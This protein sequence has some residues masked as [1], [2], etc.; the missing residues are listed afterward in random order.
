VSPSE[1]FTPIE[2]LLAADDALKIYQV[3]RRHLYQLKHSL[4]LPSVRFYKALFG[5]QTRCMQGKYRYWVWEHISDEWRIY[6]SNIRGMGFEVSKSR[7]DALLQGS[8]E[9]Q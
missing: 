9:T 1:D 2:N 4:G 5:R 3:N 8:A 6:V 7:L